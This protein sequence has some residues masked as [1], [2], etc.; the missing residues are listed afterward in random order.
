MAAVAAHPARRVIFI[1]G[2][3]PEKFAAVVEVFGNL[4]IEGQQELAERLV[5]AI[6]IYRLR[7][8]GRNDPTPAEDQKLLTRIRQHARDLLADFEVENS[9]SHI[10]NVESALR[11]R[12]S[13]LLLTEL[14]RLANERSS[15]EARPPVEH[16][17][18]AVIVSLSDLTEAAGRCAKAASQKSLRRGKTNRRGGTSHQGPTEKTELLYRL[19][20]IHE[21]VREQSRSR[22][23]LPATDARRKQFVRAALVLAASSAPPVGRYELTDKACGPD[24][25]KA[26]ITTDRSIGAAYSRWEKHRSKRA[27][28]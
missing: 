21:T 26:S 11:S 3:D 28:I 2:M 13:G 14:Y 4:P 6:G 24:L 27:R 9:A 15:D 12:A 17:L 16:R 22:K 7:Y 20:E 1:G 25:S 23:K 8:T 5:G 18:A 10:A 19:F